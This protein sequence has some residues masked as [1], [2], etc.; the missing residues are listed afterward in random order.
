MANEE[1]GVKLT[2][3]QFDEFLKAVVEAMGGVSALAKRSTVDKSNLSKMVR[4]L[5]KPQPLLLKAL[6]IREERTYILPPHW[7]KWFKNSRA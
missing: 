7:A 4:G 6:K 2:A 1:A 3:E 5:K